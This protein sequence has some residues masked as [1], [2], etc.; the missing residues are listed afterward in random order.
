MGEILTGMTK[1]VQ[2]VLKHCNYVAIKKTAADL[3][4]L[5]D[6]N[7]EEAWKYVVNK[8]KFLFDKTLT[9]YNLLETEKE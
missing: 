4:D 8:G 3:K 6:Y 2:A 5:E 7:M 1:R 9:E